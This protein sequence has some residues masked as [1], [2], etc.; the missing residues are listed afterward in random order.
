[1]DSRVRPQRPQRSFHKVAIESREERV[2]EKSEK[3]PSGGWEE[4]FSS[5]R[6][7][8]GASVR[9]KWLALLLVASPGRKLPR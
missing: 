3:R 4:L 9:R 1:M 5:R 7:Q 8:R 2:R 6:V